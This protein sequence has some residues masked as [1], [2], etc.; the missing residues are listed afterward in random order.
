[1]QAIE[2][3]YDPGQNI[4]VGSNE[5]PY[6]QL[7]LEEQNRMSISIE[8]RDRQRSVLFSKEEIQDLKEDLEIRDSP[9]VKDNFEISLGIANQVCRLL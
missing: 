7:G 5:I 6:L 9:D 1:M 3:M 8:P 4:I 2:K